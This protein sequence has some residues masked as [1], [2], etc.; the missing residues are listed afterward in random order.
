MK[1]ANTKN[2]LIPR[3]RSQQPGVTLSWK[4][5]QRQVMASTAPSHLD[6]CSI[7]CRELLYNKVDLSYKSGIGPGAR[8]GTTMAAVTDPAKMTTAQRK[9]LAA[10]VAKDKTAGMSGAGLRAK[11]GEWLTGPVRRT[12]FREFGHDALIAGSYDRA[13]ARKR[14]EAAVKP[15]KATPAAK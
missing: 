5:D 4:P 15:A 14:R 1:L 3:I 12:L 10:K 6:K 11:Y 13:A 2:K 9:A 7:T 8:K